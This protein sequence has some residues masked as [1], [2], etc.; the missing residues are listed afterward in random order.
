MASTASASQEVQTLGSCS[1]G[2]ARYELEVDREHGHYEV[3]FDLD[4][5]RSGQQWRLKLFH[6]GDR[7]F[8]DVRRTDGEREVDFERDR[9]DTAGKDRFHA[10]ARNLGNGEFCSVHIVRR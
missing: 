9:P 10:T 2:K 1:Q 7:V 3:S 5:N 4:S 8:N 6:D